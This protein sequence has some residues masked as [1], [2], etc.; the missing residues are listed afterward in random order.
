MTAVPQSMW[1]IASEWIAHAMY[2]TCG[3]MMG[4]LW[5]IMSIMDRSHLGISG[6]TPIL[7]QPP[8]TI[9]QCQLSRTCGL[10]PVMV[11]SLPPNPILLA[12]PH[13]IA[14][15]TFSSHIVCWSTPSPMRSAGCIWCSAIFM[16]FVIG[17][18]IGKG[19]VLCVLKGSCC[20]FTPMRIDGFLPCFHRQRLVDWAASW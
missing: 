9:T 6:I 14:V 5:S 19:R 10:I 17:V 1:S 12:R 20:L 13:V 15:D 7:S 16:S 2:L 3:Y 11:V 4:L 18:G 8:I